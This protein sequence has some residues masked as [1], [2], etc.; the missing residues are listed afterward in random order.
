MISLFGD[1]FFLFK[2][3]IVTSMIV[4]VA[5]SIMWGNTIKQKILMI[6]LMPTNYTPL[7]MYLIALN[8]ML[9]FFIILTP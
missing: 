7:A 2:L 3:S 4:D 9:I 5:L 6:L 1:T 8:G